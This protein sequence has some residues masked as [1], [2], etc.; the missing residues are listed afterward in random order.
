V[1]PPLRCLVIGLACVAAALAGGLVIA[2]AALTPQWSDLVLGPI[3]E[4][5]IRVVVGFSVIFL[6]WPGV[7]GALALILMSEALAIRSPLF[8][9]GSGALLAAALYLASRNWDTLALSVNGFARR[10]LE[11]MAAAGIV[12][13]FAYWVIAGRRAG[14]WRADHL[15][16]GSSIGDGG[17]TKHGL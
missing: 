4:T 7:L 10:E 12:A 2:I 13:G 9:A 16:R 5:G 11:I 6:S 8:Y 17:A 15:P 1:P 3:G 14:A